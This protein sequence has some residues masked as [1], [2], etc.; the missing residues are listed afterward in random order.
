MMKNLIRILCLGIVLAWGSS[1]DVE[2]S[3]GCWGHSFG[4]DWQNGEQCYAD[5]TPEDGGTCGWARI[6]VSGDSGLGP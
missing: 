5:E 2:A 6:D 4:C 3:T 1:R